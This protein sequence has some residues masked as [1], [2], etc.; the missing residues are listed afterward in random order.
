MIS[1]LFSYVDI[2][3]VAGSIPAAPTIQPL[4]K[5]RYFSARGPLLLLMICAH[6]CRQAGVDGRAGLVAVDV[7]AFGPAVA[8]PYGGSGGRLRRAV[9]TALMAIARKSA[10]L[11]LGA[12]ARQLAIEL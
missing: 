10:V 6:R 7:P 4:E 3:G 1:R 12:P 2:V 5:P 11:Q 9:L 8:E